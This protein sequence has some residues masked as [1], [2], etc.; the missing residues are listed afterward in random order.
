M[1]GLASGR[2]FECPLN[3]YVLSDA[4]G[5]STIHVNR[6]LRK[7]RERKLMKFG[8][9]TV[10]IHDAGDLKALAGYESPDDGETIIPKY[11]IA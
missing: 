11:R 6:V 10:V 5:L 9:H 2:E 3:Q 4:L 1:V 8:R 7:L